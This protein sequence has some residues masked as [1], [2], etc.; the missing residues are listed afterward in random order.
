MESRTRSAHACAT[1][2]S[3]ASS[4]MRRVEHVRWSATGVVLRTGISTL[5]STVSCRNSAM[6]SKGSRPAATSFKACEQGLVSMSTGQR[7]LSLALM[8]ATIASS[9]LR[10]AS[11]ARPLELNGCPQ[12]RL[13]VSLRCDHCQPRLLDET[14]QR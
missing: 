13:G 10:A 12:H 14:E 1:A 3:F 11:G 6:S 2:V 4:P 7:P 8:R 9:P 5:G